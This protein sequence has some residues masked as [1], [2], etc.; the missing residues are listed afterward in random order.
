MSLVS[1]GPILVLNI[2]AKPV[3]FDVLGRRLPPGEEIEVDPS[4][5]VTATAL[6]RGSLMV[7]SDS[8]KPKPAPKPAPEPVEE[9]VE[10]QVEES[11]PEE[12]EESADA[13][14]SVESADED[15]APKKRTS[16]RSKE[17]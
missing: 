14:D 2:S 12:A 7:L 5:P 6:S 17:S 8:V 13:D 11:A 15:Q 16:T 9:K 4:D 1:S 10:E 3:K